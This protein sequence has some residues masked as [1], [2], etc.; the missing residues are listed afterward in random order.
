MHDKLF[1]CNA[2]L[3]K[4]KEMMKVQTGMAYKKSRMRAFT[5]LK[6]KKI[7]ESQLNAM[8]NQINNLDQ[9]EFNTETIQSSL[10]TVIFQPIFRPKQ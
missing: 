6:R 8:M 2:E 10:E 1:D 5:L 9:L 7:Y 4:L 3:S